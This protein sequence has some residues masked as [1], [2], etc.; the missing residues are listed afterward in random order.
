GVTLSAPAG[1]KVN[2]V[3]DVD[4]AMDYTFRFATESPISDVTVDID[5]P[6]YLTKPNGDSN[7]LKDVGLDSH[8]SLVNPGEFDEALSGLGFPTGD[9]VKGKTALEFVLTD[10]IKLLNSDTDSHVH[11]FTITIKTDGRPDYVQTL[12]FRN[13]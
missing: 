11:K 13:K 1:F 3:N 10:L 5:S 2:D 7:M 6:D 9:E 12:Q 8:F 4:E